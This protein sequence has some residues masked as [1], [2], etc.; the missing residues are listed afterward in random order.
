MHEGQKCI[1]C[2]RSDLIKFVAY[3]QW[4]PS[5]SYYEE[6]KHKV[7]KEKKDLGDIQLSMERV[8][9]FSLRIYYPVKRSHALASIQLLHRT[10]RGRE[11]WIHT[12]A[13]QLERGI[14]I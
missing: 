4:T 12:N 1:P 2:V 6:G 13:L 9:S 10:N 7:Y 11:N 3:H 8:N 5:Q 14:K